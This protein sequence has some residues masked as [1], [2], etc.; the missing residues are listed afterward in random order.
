MYRE[1]GEIFYFRN[2]YTPS[3]ENKEFWENGL[4]PW[5][6]MEDIRKNGKILSDSIQK[7]NFKGIR[8]KIFPKNSIIISTTATIGQHALIK[9]EHVA[10]QQFTIICLKEEYF[11]LVNMKFIYYYFFIVG[12]WC[13]KNIESG[14]IDRVNIGRLKKFKIFIPPL[15]RQNEIVHILDSF[16][17]LREKIIGNL[18]NEIK[19][20]EKQFKYYRDKLFRD[21]I[22]SK[23][24]RWKNV[25][26][27]CEILNSRRKP[28]AKTDRKKGK[29]PY[30]GANGILD[31]VDNYVFDGE[32]L[33]VGEDGSVINEDNSPV[34][35]WAVGK[36]VVNNHA[37]V[38][39]GKE[40]VKLRYLYYLLQTVNVRKLIKGMPRKFGKKDL[41][42]IKIPIPKMEEQERIILILDKFCDLVERMKEELFLEIDNFKKRYDYYRVKIFEFGKF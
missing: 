26:E 37:H 32:F 30:Y 9:V 3:K 34:L 35:N 29:F 5:F 28:I 22:G 39:V 24:F 41:M 14:S 40:G 12:E 2:G 42:E 33:L 17:S 15:E 16:F 18:E 25:G 27:V 1:L 38:L 13:R 20:R 19:L 6:R 10:N 31:F 4:I 36:I 21:I 23:K 11:K 8:G 7:I